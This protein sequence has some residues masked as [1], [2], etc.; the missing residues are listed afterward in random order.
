[1][2]VR[3]HIGLLPLYLELYDRSNPGLRPRHEAF[4]A[5]VVERLGS[6]GLDVTPAPICRLR[7]EFQAAVANLEAA[8]CD[9]LVTLHIAYSP[10]L[11]SAPVL[12]KSPLPVVMLDTTPTE[13]FDARTKS[14]EILYNHGIHGVQDL[15]NMLRR[16]GKP[17]RVEAGHWENSDVLERVAGWARA[18]AAAQSLRT[19]RVGRMGEPFA[20]MGDFYVGAQTLRETLGIETVAT[21]PSAI[22]QTMPDAHAPEVEQEMALDRERFDATGVGDKL[23]RLTTRVCLALRRFVHDHGLTAVSMNFLEVTRDCGL[24]CVPFLEAS[25]GM[26]RG[27]GYA[28]EGD[29]LTAALVGA[30]ARTF[31]DTTFTEM[32]CPDWRGGT[33]FLS[34]MGEL[35]LDLAA[36]KPVM[37]E[38]AWPY[39]DAQP[40][41]VAVAAIRPGEAVIV[42]IA[43]GPDATYGI[44]A[45]P[46]DIIEHGD[47][48]EFATS[49]RAWFRPRLALSDCLQ[50]YSNAGGTHHSA[51]VMGDRT[52]DIERFASMAGLPC[53]TLGA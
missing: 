2:P 13:V 26:M 49:M 50:A 34:H 47:D 52:R 6:L 37:L 24:P 5:E 17:Y 44:V 29:V 20:G 19:A 12:A 38:K 53:V 23:H 15:A 28:G 18:A 45:V 25:K 43:P 10:S 8:G 42:N 40:P 9:A 3:A 27:L 41:V 16:L 21:T 14:E 36:G 51:M 4:L 39:T 35:N 31:G 48:Q 1:M 46:G 7:A 11:E 30:L 22:A 32:F 33:V